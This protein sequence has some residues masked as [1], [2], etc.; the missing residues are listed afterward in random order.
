VSVFVDGGPWR[1]RLAAL[2]AVNASSSLL[3]TSVMP[4][5]TPRGVV[6]FENAGRYARRVVVASPAVGGGASTD[7]SFTGAPLVDAIS[8]RV[9]E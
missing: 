4:A 1:L 8:S 7:V 9:V 2:D 5:T 3:T 6:V